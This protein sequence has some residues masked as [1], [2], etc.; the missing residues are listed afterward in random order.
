M[1]TR[2]QW[3]AVHVFLFDTL[4]S[5]ACLLEDIMPSVRELLAQGRASDWFFIRYWE[6][7]PHL[8]IR[9]ADIGSEDRRRFLDQVGAK[10]AAR[11]SGS[12]MTRDEY[13]GQHPFDGEPVRVDELPWFGDGQAVEIPYAPEIARYGGPDALRLGERMFR[14]SSDLAVNLVGATR[15]D[16]DK[17]LGAAFV[18]M[19]AVA[20]VAAR[21]GAGMA[22]FCEHYAAMWAHHSEHS[23][24]A[25]GGE[26]PQPSPGHF[27]TVAS[28]IAGKPLPS[29]FGQR[30]HD[31]LSRY[32]AE[33]ERLGRDGALV[34]PIDGAPAD[35]PER[36][37]VAIVSI[38]WSQMHM[39]NNRLA[40]LPAQEVVLARMV[41]AAAR[42]NVVEQ[43]DAP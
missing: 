9:I 28:V 31:A 34:S 15:S 2:M 1:T 11:R 32:R 8:R 17:R 13:Y 40:V 38:L 20:A 10:A 5:E 27:A 30:W 3:W 6:G 14:A 19:V 12:G 23:R 39:L 37:D 29:A 4:E 33:L 18:L 36:I 43:A 24:A 16:F 7:G 42:G 25:S 22:T 35:T 26:L 21:D 41:A